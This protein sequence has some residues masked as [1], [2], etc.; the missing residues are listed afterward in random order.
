VIAHMR[1][2]WRFVVVPGDGWIKQAVDLLSSDSFRADLS[3]VENPYGTGGASKR[4]VEILDRVEIDA[5]LKK[6]FWNSAI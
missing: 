1:R 6:G 3:S 5:L 2:N 4:I